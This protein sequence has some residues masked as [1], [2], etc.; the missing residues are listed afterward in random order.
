MGK[1]S[2]QDLA[3]KMGVED[4]DLIFKLKS[5]GVQLDA[6]GGTNRVNHRV[7]VV[8]TLNGDVVYVNHHRQVSSGRHFNL[9]A[10]YSFIFRVLNL[11]IKVITRVTTIGVCDINRQGRQQRADVQRLV[12]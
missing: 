3:K 2:V 7:R 12:C 8:G 11:A 6:V 9:V 1:I 5:I 4:Q 10:R